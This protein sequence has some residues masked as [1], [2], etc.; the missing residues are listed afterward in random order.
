MGS[1]PMTVSNAQRGPDAF[2]PEVVNNPLQMG[3]TFITD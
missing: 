3:G 1:T 2:Q